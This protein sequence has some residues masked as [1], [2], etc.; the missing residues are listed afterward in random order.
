[1]FKKIIKINLF[2]LFLSTILFAEIVNDINILG[3][4]RLSKESIIVFGDISKDKEYSLN[5]LNLSLKKLYETNFF[6]EVNLK[7]DN[8]ILVIKVIENP[9]IE[10]LSI[11]GIKKEKFKKILLE[12]MELKSRKSYVETLFLNDLNLIKN[13]IKNSGYYFSEI[14]T[15]VVKNEDQNSIRL[16]YDINLGEKARI[17][18]IVFL[19]DKKIKDRTL[20]NIITSE[21]S[22]FWKF[23]S[24]KIYLDRERINLDTRLLLSY[25]KNRGF[26]NAKVVNSFVEFQDN[27]FFKLIFNIDSGNKFYFNNLRLN[28][29]NDYDSNHF[30]KI[31]NL[32]KEIENDPY[33]LNRI[34]KILKEIDKI[35]LL[36]QYEFVNANMTETITDDNKIDI[37]IDLDETEKFYVEKINIKGNQITLEEVIRNSFIVD[38]GD[39]FNEILFNKSLNVIRSKNIFK[40]VK[41]DILDG[42]NEN[43]KI[44]DLTVEEKPTGEISLGAGV[45]TSGGTMGGG[46]KENNF[47]GKGIRLDTNVAISKNS[48]KGKFV[49]S[50]PNFNY[51]DNTL[52]AS[53][54]S[55]STD[56]LKDFGYETSKI[57]VALGT[58]FEQFNNLFFS[59]EFS[60]TIEELD[61]TSTASANIKKQEGNYTDLYFN[62]N[63]SYDMR[64]QSYRTTEGY[65][66][67]FYQELPFVSE[68]YE[69]INSF[70]TTKYQPLIGDM[71][72][73]IRFHAKA[74]N[75]LKNNDVRI[76]KRLFMPGSK[77]RG[78]EAGKIGPFQN[79]DH[80]GGNYISS[81]N[82]STNLP[83]VLPS[84]ENTDFSFF[85]DAGNVWGVD[86]DSSVDN[87]NKIRSSTGIAIDII[88]P[89]GPVNFTLSQAIS[90]SSTDKT[91]S[92]RF[93]LGT[94]F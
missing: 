55:T 81:I 72:G 28:I 8:N 83:Q 59:P 10:D 49:Y 47:L 24:N 62:H 5:D 93:N 37:T 35:A 25:Y 29:P 69:I 39:P 92:F 56:N 43:Y 1:M 22:R 4:K 76:S 67:S 26:Y 21:E 32:L 38:E 50:Q 73:K 41:S 33:S 77:L 89:I 75:T 51:S 11:N 68:N 82:L 74:V 42:S 53:V 6:K 65:I 66:N 70:T 64:N 52:F 48:L 44:I 80:V 85:I 12:S 84:L 61:T 27:N 34:N 90:K 19:G 63:W 17:K 30:V 87:A 9:I 3:N 7:I 86:Y 40:S 57:G 16:T 60:F 71:I 45:G 78:F 58:T 20:L 13:I 31:N 14:K 36:K 79:N 91:E 46:I 23:I 54:K 88:T 94:T 18:E 15:S 2:V